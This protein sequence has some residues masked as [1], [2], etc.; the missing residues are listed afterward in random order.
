MKIQ[1]IEGNFTVCQVD[2]GVPIDISRP[3]TFLSRTDEELSL[4]CP[5]ESVPSRTIQR[6]DGW[7]MLRIAGTRDFA[8]VGIL[9]R[10]GA[11][12]ADAH[13]PIFAISTYNT[14]YILV[15]DVHFGHALHTLSEYGYD[16]ETP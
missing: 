1:I 2:G 10:I 14:D 15:K 8:L 6:E 16:V 9:S 13:I 5:C 11:V 12:L 7:R 4:V 3:F